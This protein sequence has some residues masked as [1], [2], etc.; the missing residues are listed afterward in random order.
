[1]RRAARTDAN[2]QSV[3]EIF[4]AH[5]CHVHS[6]ARLGDGFPDLLIGWHDKI[7]LVEVKRGKGTL[8]PDQIKFHSVW[9]VFT[10]RDEKAATEVVQWLKRT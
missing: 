4:E 3:V 2:Q 7:A 10:V 9:P 8:T 6:A 1:M 5:G